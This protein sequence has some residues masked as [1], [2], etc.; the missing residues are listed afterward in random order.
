MSEEIKILSVVQDG[1]DG[2]IV[3]FS[4]GTIGGYVLEELL[5]LRPAREQIK[6]LGETERQV[7][8]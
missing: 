4:D 6:N 1:E 3:T 7:S 5:E 2:I 8:T